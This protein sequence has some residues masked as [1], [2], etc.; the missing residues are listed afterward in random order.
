MSVGFAL[1][2][3]PAGRLTLRVFLVYVLDCCF[4]TEIARFPK[5]DSC[6]RLWL[7]T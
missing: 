2:N 4:V 1:Q 7:E 5:L 3:S 6:L